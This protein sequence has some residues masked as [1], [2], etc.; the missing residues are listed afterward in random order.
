MTRSLHSF[1]K[2]SVRT[3]FSSL[4][5][6]AL[7]SA[8]LAHSGA[9]GIVKERMEGMK[10]MSNATKALGAMQAGA[11]PFSLDTVTF[12]AGEIGQSAQAA[13]D[14]FPDGSIDGPSEALPLIFAEREKFD[15]LLAELE[16]LAAQLGE[17]Q[18]PE[19]VADLTTRIG[20]NCK[21]CH[22]RYRKK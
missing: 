7:A 3:V 1:G 2:P 13:R 20:D 9:T 17:S 22:A 12:V 16:T 19:A 15:A 5:L 4:A 8:A 6:V 10:I 21:S 18:E 14:Q 11:I